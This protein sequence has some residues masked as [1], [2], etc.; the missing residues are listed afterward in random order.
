MGSVSGKG[1]RGALRS[2]LRGA[3]PAASVSVDAQITA[4]GEAL[5]GQPLA[6]DS[7][8][9]DTG[10]LD[11]YTRA[12][13]AYEEAKRVFAAGRDREDVENAVHALDEGR[14]ALARVEA[15][16]AG[17]PLPPARPLCFFDPRHGPS[18]IDIRWAPPEGARRTI[19]VCAA[20]AARLADGLPPVTTGRVASRAAR[21][22]DRPASGGAGRSTSPSAPGTVPPQATE[23][24]RRTT[25]R[26]GRWHGWATPVGRP[27]RLPARATGNARPGPVTRIWNW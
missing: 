4:F 1:L 18:S 15:R 11:D 24:E 13:D 21:P 17:R 6:A 2:L 26:T 8:G 23:A 7:G 10:L 9:A 25:E 27:P 22:G 16:L 20:D 12:L 5:A 19:A 14:N 3:D